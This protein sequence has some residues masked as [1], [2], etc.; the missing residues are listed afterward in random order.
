M[1]HIQAI[2]R[3]AAHALAV[4]RGRLGRRA[5][6]RHIDAVLMRE[7]RAQVIARLF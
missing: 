1:R 5:A 3:A 4:A 6:L 7:A 2:I